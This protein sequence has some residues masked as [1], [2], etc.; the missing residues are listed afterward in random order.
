[1]RR[2][3]EKCIEYPSMRVEVEVLGTV[4]QPYL[5]VQHEAVAVACGFKTQHECSVMCAVQA[6]D[7]IEM[8]NINHLAT[9]GTTGGFAPMI[10]AAAIQGLKLFTG[11][12]DA[13]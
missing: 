8:A 4:D 6:L 2:D 13:S 3:D 12:Y 1:M 11:G 5:Q 9:L 7:N 10:D